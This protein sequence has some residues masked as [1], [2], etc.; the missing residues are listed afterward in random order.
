MIASMSVF[1]TSSIERR[2]N[3]VVS[4]AAVYF[5]P[6]GKNDSCDAR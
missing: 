6:G 4:N 5:N 2:M 1:T 3:G